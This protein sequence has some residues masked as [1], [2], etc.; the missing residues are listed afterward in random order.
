MILLNASRDRADSPCGLVH[1]Q[2]H[3]FGLFT[4]GF[5]VF[6][7][8]AKLKLFYFLIISGSG[9]ITYSTFRISSV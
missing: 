3:V 7:K 2:P 9:V 6:Y 4:T 1:V 8:N 5:D